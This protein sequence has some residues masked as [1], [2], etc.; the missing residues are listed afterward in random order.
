MYN[1][2]KKIDDF[3]NLLIKSKSF[4]LPRTHKKSSIQKM[5]E[6]TKLKHRIY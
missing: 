1:E 5:L 4:E 6:F 2:I 3:N